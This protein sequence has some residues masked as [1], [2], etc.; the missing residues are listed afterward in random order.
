MKKLT[1]LF[2]TLAIAFTLSA[3]VFAKKH[4]PTKKVHKKSAFDTF[5]R[6]GKKKGP[7]KDQ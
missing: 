6:Y 1:G 4:H 5:L 7:M 3:P 2:A